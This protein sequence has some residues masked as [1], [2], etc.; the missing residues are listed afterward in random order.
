MSKLMMA[1]AFG[2]GYVL[3]AK[4]GRERYDQLS[5]KAQDLWS[6]PKVQEKA[7]TLQEQAKSVLASGDPEDV[8][9]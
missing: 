5:T 4:A 2:A 8:R 9:G 3:G 1:A 7:A 6:N